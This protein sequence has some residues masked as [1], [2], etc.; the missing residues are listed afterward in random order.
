MENIEHKT[1]S[2]PLDMP[3]DKRISEVGREISKWIKKLDQL[4]K[5]SKDE[6]GKVFL[7]RCEKTKKEYSYQYSII[8]PKNN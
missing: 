4:P 5:S 8:N 6:M 1:I 3:L 7:T 2:L